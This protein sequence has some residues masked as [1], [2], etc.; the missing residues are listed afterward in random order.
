MQEETSR[1]LTGEGDCA[2][3]LRMDFVGLHLFE[4]GR[5]LKVV[6]LLNV[7]GLMY[8]VHGEKFTRLECRLEQLPVDPFAEKEGVSLGV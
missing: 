8:L 6:L 1:E 2:V 5:A 7:G 4:G 3:V